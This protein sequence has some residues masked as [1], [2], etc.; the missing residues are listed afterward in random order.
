MMAYQ[1]PNAPA[2]PS[3]P[4]R[5]RSLALSVGVSDNEASRADVEALGARGVILSGGPDSVYDEGARGVDQAILESGLPIL[6]VCY[7]MQLLA[8]QLGG[9]VEPLT[10]RR[11]YGPAAITL[12]DG[13]DRL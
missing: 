1:R 5:A 8:H 9:H 12:R 3:A 10:G 2:R 6:G 7:G 11:E 4:M 13:A